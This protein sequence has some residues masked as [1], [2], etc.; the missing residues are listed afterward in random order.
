LLVL[1]EAEFPEDSIPIQEIVD[2]LLALAETSDKWAKKVEAKKTYFKETRC[3]IAKLYS[4]PKFAQEFETY[5]DY[6]TMLLEQMIS[7]VNV[8]SY[9]GLSELKTELV[10]RR[11]D[12]SSQEQSIEIMSER[13][14]KLQESICKMQE[15]RNIS[16]QR[17]ELAMKEAL[18]NVKVSIS[19]DQMTQ[20]HGYLDVMTEE[21]GQTKQGIK[22]LVE[23]VAS[24]LEQQVS[25]F[26]R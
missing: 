9:K 19:D 6:L 24:C 22:Q 26:I 4:A 20:L 13:L 10:A 21:V 14:K 25:L 11:S 7:M 3:A 16:D 1:K 8:E 23:H 15:D 5:L 2:T 17:T 12:L 18:Q